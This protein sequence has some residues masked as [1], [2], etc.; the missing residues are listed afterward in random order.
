M[1]GNIAV[2]KEI[3][4]LIGFI[5]PFVAIGFSTLFFGVAIVLSYHWR[6]YG[7]AKIKAAVFML[8]YLAGGLI[9]IAAMI[10]ANLS[11]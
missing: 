5:M 2:A 11:Y 9:L 7:V 1:L 6:K 10:T 4:S 8:I 3:P